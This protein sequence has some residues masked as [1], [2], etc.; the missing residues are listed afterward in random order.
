MSETQD[1]AAKPTDWERIEAQYSAGTMSLREIAA[2]HDITEGAIRKRAKKDGWTRDLSARV[3]AKADAIVR[4]ALVEVEQPKERGPITATEAQTIEVEAAV[5]AR[6]RLAHRSNITRLR[7]LALKLITECEAE[8]DQ[9]EVFEQLGEIMRKPDEKGQDRL[10]D[11]YQKA[12]SLPQRIKGV[13]ELTETLQRL[14]TMERESYG[15]TAVVEPPATP[16]NL[17]P[18]EAARRLA[19]LLT[20]AT[21]QHGSS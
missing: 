1:K 5:Q 15:I 8:S 13:K 11:A 6:I 21:H 14:V 16:A 20:R 4:K 17:D 7:D 12:I 3:H 9:P 19:F 2:A 18:V 10:N